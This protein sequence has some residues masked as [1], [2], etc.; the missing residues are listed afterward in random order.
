[1]SDI[2]ARTR[3]ARAAVRLIESGQTVFLSSGCGEP[4][5]LVDALIAE[6]ENFRNLRLITGVQG[7]NTPYVAP[8]YAAHFRLATFM[9]SGRIRQA[10]RAGYADHIPAP[11]SQI[12]R[13]LREGI[14]PID[15]A[16][17]QVAPPDSDGNCSLGV[18]I[19]Y[20]KAAVEAA[21]L[22]IAEVNVRM[23]RTL[24]DASIPISRIGVIVESDRDVLEVRASPVND[25]LA[26]IGRHVASLVPERATMQIGVGAT[27]E[28]IWSGL[29]D[30]QDLSVHSGSVA[31]GVID[32]IERGV[33][34]NRFKSLDRGK[35][36]VGQ[37]IGTTKLYTYAH[38]NPIFDM[39]QADYTHNPAV[40]ARLNN[41]VSVNSALQVDL[42][43]QINAET[44]NGDQVAGVG[45][46]IDFAYGATFAPGG[47]SIIALPSTAGGGKYSRIVP[48]LDDAVVTTPGTLV[49]YVVTEYGVAD[50]R[51]KSLTARAEALLRIAHPIFKDVLSRRA[52]GQT[53]SD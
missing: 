37:L 50:L 14:I 38:E 36:I 46:A 22:V 15:V 18:S 9:A 48:K 52:A 53:R 4:Q 44:I 47:H 33:V 2:T 34:T 20:A 42:R 25:V 40:L 26:V 28:A 27:A 41:F 31:D 24:G 5:E 1:M 13:L 12:P 19:A 29:K 11:L 23:P 30:R 21:K 7:S 17:V 6:R 10:I 8:E 43:G 35:L 3:T 51:G 16:M 45:G 49:G 39:R 32:L